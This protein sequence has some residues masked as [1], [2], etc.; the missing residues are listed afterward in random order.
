MPITATTLLFST[1]YLCVAVV[2]L[3]KTVCVCLYAYKF[4]VRATGSDNVTSSN[5]CY[6]IQEEDRVPYSWLISLEKKAHVLREGGGGVQGGTEKE[7]G[8]GGGR[9]EGV[10]DFNNYL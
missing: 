3:Y 5:C 7:S 6:V 2:P 10:K 4:P 9:E 1:P 8:R